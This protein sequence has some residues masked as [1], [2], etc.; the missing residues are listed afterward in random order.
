MASIRPWASLVFVTLL[1]CGGATASTGSDPTEDGRTPAISTDAPPS[2]PSRDPST[3]APPLVVNPGSTISF[4]AKGVYA[5]RDPTNAPCGQKQPV[6]SD[7]DRFVLQ[8][9]GTASRV[10]SFQGILISTRNAPAVGTAYPMQVLAPEKF[11]AQQGRAPGDVSLT[12]YGDRMLD[13]LPLETPFDTA[14]VTILAFPTHDG[15]PLTARVQL[16]FENGDTF[17]ATFSGN[18]ESSQGPCGGSQAH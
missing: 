14:T 5:R 16:H 2:T 17:D 12:V 6:F 13:G 7:Q 18:V 1:G 4:T 8:L 3:P 15:E 9:V 11:G 10:P